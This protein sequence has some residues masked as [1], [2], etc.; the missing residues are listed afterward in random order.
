[1]IKKYLDFV[2][3][4][5]EEE[6]EEKYLNPNTDVEPDQDERATV[7]KWLKDNEIK[8]RDWEFDGNHVLVYN[9]VVPGHLPG[10]KYI[11][12]GDVA[13]FTRKTVGLEGT[14]QSRQ[15]H[16]HLDSP[17]KSVV[18]QNNKG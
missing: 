5:K 16:K 1:M 14:K 12:D 7:L 9:A 8:Y 17:V 2:N 11:M 10:G 18:N 13:K 3:E 6:T 4:A 15:T